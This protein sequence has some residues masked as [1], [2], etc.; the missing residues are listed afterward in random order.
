M[1]DERIIQEVH[2][3]RSE[4]TSWMY[5]ALI[6]SMLVKELVLNL[7][8]SAC[9]LEL[10]L[11]IAVPVYQ[12]VRL[13]MLGVGVE[14]YS[15][16]HKARILSVLSSVLV[17]AAIYIYLMVRHGQNIDFWGIIINIAIFAGAFCF[18]NYSIQYITVRRN[19]KLA[20]QYD[21]DNE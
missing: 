6:V 18:I 11:M 19:Q 8:A 5:L 17:Y 9:I 15:K 1:K 2:K 4:I 10:V 13:Q 3:V 20:D 7:P 16:K 12:F 21:D 14:F